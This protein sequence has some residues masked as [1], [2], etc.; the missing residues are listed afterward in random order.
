MSANKLAAADCPIYP[1]VWRRDWMRHLA[2]N[3]QGLDRGD[4]QWPHECVPF[5]WF[6]LERN[7]VSSFVVSVE[8]VD[9]GEA[10][11]PSPEII[12]DPQRSHELYERSAEWIRAAMAAPDGTLVPGELNDV[13]VGRLA[14][15]ALSQSST[16]YTFGG[17]EETNVIDACAGEAARAELD[18]LAREVLSLDVLAWWSEDFGADNFERHSPMPAEEP[19]EYA[20]PGEPLSDATIRRRMMRDYLPSIRRGLP[21]RFAQANAVFRDLPRLVGYQWWPTSQIVRRDSWTSYRRTLPAWIAESRQEIEARWPENDV[22]ISI[23]FSQNEEQYR[24]AVCTEQLFGADAGDFPVDRLDRLPLPREGLRVATVSSLSDWIGLVERYP[25]VLMPQS[26][27][28]FDSWMGADSGFLITVD[29]S[30]LAADYD[31]IYLPISGALDA[32]HVPARVTIAGHEAEEC[33]TLMVGWVP[34]SVIWINNPFR[35]YGPGDD[36]VGNVV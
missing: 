24:D 17:Y 5:P 18:A 29:W 12:T 16:W 8:A 19:L 34:G 2:E 32:M 3:I 9:V 31:G 14:L 20:A 30:A 36:V 27:G 4:A 28:E 25:M 15:R 23:G 7:G 10:A 11:H 1:G 33:R 35:G 22:D 13:V 26:S 6:R 21:E